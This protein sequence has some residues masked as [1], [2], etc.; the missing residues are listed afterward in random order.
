MAS[1]PKAK[2]LTERDRQILQFV[3]QGGI[4]RLDQLKRRHWPTAQEQTARDRLLQLEKAGWLQSHFCHQARKHNNGLVFTLTNKGAAHFTSAERKR[5]TIG[6]P[7]HGELVQQLVGQDTRIALEIRLAAQGRRLVQWRSE[8]ELR[9]EFYGDQ[10]RYNRQRGRA[11]N[12]SA[13]R[14]TGRPKD[15]DDLYDAQAVIA[16]QDGQESQLGIEIDGQ[17]YGKMLDKKLASFTARPDQPLIWATTSPLRAR[18]IEQALAAYS[19]I[20]VLLIQP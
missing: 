9:S 20:E 5:F 19:H 6:L 3:G 16:G 15:V 18:R 12:A 13:S 1:K 17:Y 7:T 4:A 8:R 2:I 10:A 11:W 14:S